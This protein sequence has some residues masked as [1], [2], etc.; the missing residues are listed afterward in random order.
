MELGVEGQASFDWRR[1]SPSKRKSTTAQHTLHTHVKLGEGA[2]I[3]VEQLDHTSNF[4]H[5]DC[6]YN[7]TADF[8]RL[9]PALE[10]NFKG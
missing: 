1:A 10:T 2:P 5:G 9:S 3:L 7:E 8:L 6:A 4:L